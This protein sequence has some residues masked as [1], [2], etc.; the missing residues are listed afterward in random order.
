MPT[1]GLTKLW[2]PRHDTSGSPAQESLVA[3]VLRAR[4]L[5]GDAAREFLEPSLKLLHDPSLMPDLDK[6]AARILESAR[7]GEPIV[8][9]GDYDVD[10]ITAS[11][12]LFHILRGLVPDC[13]IATYV[14][15]RL[16]EGYG[17]NAEALAKLASDGAKIII[18]VDCGITAVAAA[19]ALAGTGVTLIITD[20][21][22]PPEDEA[23]LP[24][25]FAH[26]HPRRPGVTP[27]PFPDLSGS[28][29]AFKLAWRLATMAA[30]SQ[31]VGD[32]IRDLLLDLLALASLGVIADVVPLRGENRVIASFGLRR[33]RRTRFEGLGAL[34]EASGL[35]G[36][37]VGEEDV[38][39][40]LGPRLNA[41]GRLGHAKEAVELLTT[42]T[43]PRATAIA[44]QLS[45]LNDERRAAEKTIFEQACEMV[46]LKGMHAEGCRGIVLAHAQWHQ[47]IVGIVCSKLVERYSR[48]V[49][50]MQDHG[51]SCHGSGRSIEGFSLYDALNACKAHLTQFGGHTMAAGLKIESSRVESFAADFIEHCNQNVQPEHMVRTARFDTVAA[52]GEL[53]AATI[54]RL[55]SL[56]PFGAGNPRVYLLVRGVRVIGRAQTFGAYNKHLSFTASEAASNRGVRF[57]G[58]NWGEHIHSIPAGATIDAIVSP[59]INTWGGSA[60]VECEIVDVRVG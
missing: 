10:G 16:E 51:E 24:E 50:L 20:H 44:E 25:A 7:G 6:A 45:R 26:V 60:K 55:E 37:A 1:R 36:E 19:R 59:K 30:G 14:P 29:V 52:L 2:L 35:S 53:S 15:H 9:Y 11:A 23:D 21:H 43:G 27:Y 34:I 58:W 22:T 48:P 54:G 49:I 56:S 38:G 41:V 32:E 12:I 47:G 13:T 42:A 28:A 31:R 4:D 3:R 46:E 18:S 33:L 40:K 39:F 5:L 17:L 57:F 8:I